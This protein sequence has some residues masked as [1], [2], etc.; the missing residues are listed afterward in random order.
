MHVQCIVLRDAD[1][2]WYKNAEKKAHVL[3]TTFRGQVD[4]EDFSSPTMKHAIGL[5]RPNLFS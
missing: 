1:P 3:N 2:F 5:I 4:G